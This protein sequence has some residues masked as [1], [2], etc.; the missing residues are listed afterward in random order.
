M[1]I[2]D[3]IDLLTDDSSL[4]AVYDFRTE[5]EVFCGEAQELRFEDIREY[6]VLSVDLCH[7]DPRGVLLVLNIETEEDEDGEDD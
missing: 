6:E 7:D 5:E 1:N 2:W 3:F 4:V